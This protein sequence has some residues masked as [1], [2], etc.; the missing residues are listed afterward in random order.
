MSDLHINLWINEEAMEYILLIIISIIIVK[1]GW[2]LAFG[3]PQKRLQQKMDVQE[4]EI[5]DTE[6][7]KIISLQKNKD[8]DGLIDY[9]KYS[10]A[11]D[12]IIQRLAASALGEIRDPAAVNSLITA[13]EGKASVSAV[14]ALKDIGNPSV[15]PMISALSNLELHSP[16]RKL[17]INALGDLKSHLA[18]DSLI[19]LLNEEDHEIR[20]SVAKALNKITKESFGQD[21]EKWQH[22]WKNNKKNYQ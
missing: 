22:W 9:L 11:F 1:V 7:N 18:I 19:V 21:T 16:V 2:R 15:M 4:Y 13:L 17:L 12:D 6:K 20:K 14:C 8:V 3:S 5:L 10:G